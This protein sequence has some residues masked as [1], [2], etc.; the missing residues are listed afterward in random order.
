MEKELEGEAFNQPKGQFLYR[1]MASVLR[2]GRERTR[3]NVIT[4]VEGW[5]LG[6]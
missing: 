6:Q 1:N 2:T 5:A 4:R 3:D